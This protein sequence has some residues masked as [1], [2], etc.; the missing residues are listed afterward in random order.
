MKRYRCRECRGPRPKNRIYCSAVCRS[1]HLY[2]YCTP[3]ANREIAQND[4]AVVAALK[5]AGVPVGRWPAALW[6]RSERVARLEDELE[7]RS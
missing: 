7:G 6:M 5:A 2:G 4:V 1:L 3:A